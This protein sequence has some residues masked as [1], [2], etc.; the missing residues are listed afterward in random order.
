MYK[1]KGKKYFNI[2]MTPD[3]EVAKNVSEDQI[4]EELQEILS[5]HKGL[6]KFFKIGFAEIV[7][8]LED[9]IDENR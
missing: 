6:I 1:Q 7:E 2:Q 5:K 3:I 4:L 9:G 8:E